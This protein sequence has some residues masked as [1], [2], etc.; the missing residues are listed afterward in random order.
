M[1]LKQLIIYLGAFGI[2]A[3]AAYK[4]VGM[5]QKVKLPLITGFLVIGLISGPEIL[6]LIEAEALEKL[7][8][9]NEIALAFIAFAVG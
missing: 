3:V 6:D 2:V 4:M 5:F 7:D 9:V 8:F 1:E